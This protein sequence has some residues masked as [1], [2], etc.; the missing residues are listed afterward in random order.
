M[1][2]PT[3]KCY[4]NWYIN[5]DHIYIYS[6]LVTLNMSIYDHQLYENIYVIESRMNYS[7]P[8]KEQHM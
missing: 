2:L 8:Y 1:R 5:I 3:H 6:I 4:T 7:I